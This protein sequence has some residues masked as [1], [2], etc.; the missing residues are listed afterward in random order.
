MKNI[1]LLSFLFITSFAGAQGIDGYWYGHAN[2]ANGASANNYMVELILKQKGTSVDGIVNYYFRNTFR[3]FKIKGAYNTTSRNLSLYNIPV[4]YYAS[5]NRFEVDC[6]MNFTAL[7]RAAKA[8]SNLTG[9]FVG[10]AE[11]KN[12]CPEILFDLKLNKDA[13]NEDSVLKELR[14]F[15]ETYQMWSPSAYDTAV[16]ATIIQRPVINY[17][18]VDQY[19]EREK[20]VVKVLE[21]ESDSLILNFYDNGEVDGDSI[22]VFYNDKL[23]ASS[24]RLSAK[25]IQLKIGLDSTKEFNEISMFA[26]NLGTIPP[27]TALMLIYDGRQRYEVRLTST[28]QKSATIRFKRKKK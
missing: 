4:S 3:S 27:N 28:L 21:V 11:Y 5:T 22:S 18:V 16:A 1:I 24:Q 26:D 19:K 7:L 17:V 2:V 6:M 20:D 8:G 25:A 12:T 23:L 15:K 13:G 10:T 14:L 9:R